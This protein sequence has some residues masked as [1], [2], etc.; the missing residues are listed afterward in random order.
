[1]TRYVIRR[2]LWAVVLFLAV[3]LVTFV[4]F[5]LIPV[6]PARQ[7][8]GKAATP[9]QIQEVAHRLYLDR[10]IWQQ[11]LHFL[12]ELVHG[13]L[14]YSY[15]NRQSVNETIKQA[16]PVTASLVIGGGHP[17]AGDGGSDRRATRRCGPAPRA[18]GPPWASC[19]PASRC[20]R[21]GW[22]WWR[23]T[24][25]RSCQ[26][27]EASWAYIPIIHAVSDP[28]YCNLKGAAPR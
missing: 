10:P 27:R 23:R 4:I 9:A 13:D 24:C 1:M 15:A 17:V 26:P 6:D 25:L 8:A 18:T 3:T 19:S 5:Y 14:G 28:G 22:G 21:S 11:Y 2:L 12:D 20:T 16:A 7:A